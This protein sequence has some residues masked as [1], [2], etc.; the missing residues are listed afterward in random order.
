MRWYEMSGWND[1]TA[2]GQYGR[3]IVRDSRWP[4]MRVGEVVQNPRRSAISDHR[5][6]DRLGIDSVKFDTK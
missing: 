4:P 2:P 1:K 3:H 5:Q 6:P